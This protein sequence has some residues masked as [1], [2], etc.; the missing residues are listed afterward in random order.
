MLVT[1]TKLGLEVKVKVANLTTNAV[2]DYT[3]YIG[4]VDSKKIDK[5][6]AKVLPENL[7]FVATISVAECNKLFGV[8]ESKFMEMAIE[9]DPVTRKPLNAEAT[10]EAE[11]T[12]EAE[13]PVE[14]T[15]PIKKNNK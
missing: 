5:E 8:E 1:R 11:P 9:L 12:V 4:K 13:A 2:E 6:V 3:A 10:A 7:K 15:K 14:E